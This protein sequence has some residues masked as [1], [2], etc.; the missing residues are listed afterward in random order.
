MSRKS[1]T[2]STTAIPARPASCYPWSTLSFA[3]SGGERG[4]DAWAKGGH[5]FAAAAEAMRRILMYIARR[6]NSA[7]RGGDKRRLPLEELHRVSESPLDLLDLDDAL[8]RFALDEPDKARLVHLCFFAGLSISEAAAALGI[9]HATA[10]RWWTY[11][12]AWLFHALRDSSTKIS[13]D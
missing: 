9:F 5:F 10:E 1:Y 12:R 13:G 2:Q 6:K 3:N 11:A 4:A 8:T 7:K